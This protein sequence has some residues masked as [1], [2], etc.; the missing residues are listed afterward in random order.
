MQMVLGCSMIMEFHGLTIQIL[1]YAM[2][3][4][5]NSLASLWTM[6]TDTA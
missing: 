5:S 1:H 3:A 6:F 2:V 4:P